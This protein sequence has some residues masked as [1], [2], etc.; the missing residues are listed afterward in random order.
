MARNG[1]S[2]RPVRTYGNTYHG[3]VVR[4]GYP[5]QVAGCADCHTSHNIRPPGEPESPLNPTNLAANCAKCHSG[6][7]P[8]FVAFNAHPDY[9]DRKKYPALF[10]TLLFM[11][12]LLI[13]VFAFFWAHTGLWWRK[14]YWEKC[15]KER[16]GGLPAPCQEEQI[17]RFPVLYRVMHFFLILSFFGLVVTGLPLKYSGTTWS[18]PLFKLLGGTTG[19]GMIHRISAVI[20]TA[21]FLYTLWLSIRFLFS[22]GGLLRNLKTGEWVKRLFGP[23]SLFPNMKD[24]RDIR[25]MFRWF[26]NRGNLPLFDRWTYWEKFDFLAVFWGM[27]AI[28]GSGLILWFPEFFSFIFPGWIINVATIVHSEEALLAALFIFTVHFF[29]NHLVPEKFPLEPNIFTGRNSLDQLRNERPL[30]YE[31]LL[32][33]GR[34]DALKRKPTG[35]RSR[36]VISVVGLAALAVGLLL[37]LIIFLTVL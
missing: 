35:I 4:A 9:G 34:L 21:L 6:F 17:E 11:E 23:D 20:L 32:R 36:L 25:D 22:G 8:R 3:K 30:E 1:L 28:G 18:K 33:E 19:A 31:R 5:D 15:R 24:L 2:T 26:F 13:G 7:H 14:A 27:A 29:N 16:E 37:V 12:G 10:W